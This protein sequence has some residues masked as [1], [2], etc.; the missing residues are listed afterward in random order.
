[1]WSEHE[2]PG[3]KPACSCLM[4]SSSVAASLVC[5]ILLKILLVI[6]SRVMP[7]QLLHSPKSPFLGNLTISP[8]FHASGVVSL[9]A[10][11]DRCFVYFAPT[12]TAVL[13]ILRQQWRLFCLFCDNNDSC[14]VYFAPT[15]T[16]VLFILR[17]QWQLFCLFCANN[18]SCF[19]YF[20]PTM[21]AVL[22]ISRQ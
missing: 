5:M 9:C 4:Y 7:L 8:V 3:R 18:H 2:R 17:Q 1:M 22:F 11:N 14:F 21:T 12:N 10:N 13:F 16:A 15:M 19:V 20:A 6:G